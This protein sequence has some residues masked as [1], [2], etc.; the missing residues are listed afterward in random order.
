[1]GKTLDQKKYARRFPATLF[2][3]VPAD[4]KAWSEGRLTVSLELISTF[5][6]RSVEVAGREIRLE[7][8]TTAPLAY[9]LNDASLWKLDLAQ[10]FSAEERVRSGVY[11]S[12]PYQPGLVP[13]VFVHGTASSPIWW[14]E[15]WNTLRTDSVLREHFQFWYFV[16]PTGKPLS[17]SANRLREE[18]SRKIQQLDP[19]GKDPAL[20]QMVVIGHS[21][22]G[23]LTKLAVTD[24]GDRLWHT[25][26]TNDFAKIEV[27]PEIRGVLQTN[28]FFKPLPFIERVVFISTPHRG[29][30]MATSLVRKLA[31]MFMNL[32]QTVVN[33]PGT[34][35][36]LREQLNLPKEVRAVVPTSLDGMSPKNKWLL[37]L[38]EIPPA[39][40]V[41]AHSS[42]AVK[43][44][45]TPPPA[46]GDGVVKYTSA[47]VPYVES[48]FV[49]SSS[50][51][52][53]G[54]PAAIEE[55]RRILLLHMSEKTIP[56]NQ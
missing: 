41:K 51:S 24:S 17:Q 54:K 40:G 3:R 19:D 47:R 32:P 35:A 5:D 52:C 48:E 10:F 45:D 39:P 42:V 43:G 23:L 27:D 1:V 11:L 13:V 46:G 6:Y 37:E 49:V 8:D 44:R 50:H 38:A 22:G 31:H 21:Q 29:S 18:L 12:Q 53:Q 30:Y 28:F 34:L 4:L 56:P 26:S 20:R 15:M 25:V 33:S 2:L 7:S 55:V 14:A 36:Q 16:Y 9:G